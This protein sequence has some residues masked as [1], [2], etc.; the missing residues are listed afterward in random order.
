MCMVLQKVLIKTNLN[1][2]VMFGVLV[3]FFILWL[4]I[5]YLGAM[6]QEIKF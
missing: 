1:L 2:P 3:V 5:K 4:L 6:K